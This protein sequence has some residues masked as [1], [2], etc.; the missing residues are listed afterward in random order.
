MGVILLITSQNCSDEMD[1]IIHN[2]DTELRAW[3]HREHSL[4]HANN[5]DEDVCKLYV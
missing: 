5:S 3:S 2:S 4:V 1:M